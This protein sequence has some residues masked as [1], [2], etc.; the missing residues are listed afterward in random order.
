[1][2]SKYG[3]LESQVHFNFMIDLEFF[4]RNR[5]KNDKSRVMFITG[6]NL[7]NLPSGYFQVNVRLP[8]YGSHHTKMSLLKTKS[9]HLIGNESIKNVFSKLRTRDLRYVI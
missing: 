8:P 1:M 3:E 6:D 2:L 7:G 9:G 5:P 4:I